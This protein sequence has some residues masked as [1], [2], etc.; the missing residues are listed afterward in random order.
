[1]TATAGSTTRSV[2]RAEGFSCPSCVAKIEKRVGRLPGV[3]DVTVKFASARVEVDHD[4]SV[5]STDEI[6]AAI[7]AAGYRATLSAF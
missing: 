3:R 4:P 5:T 1:M 7:G 6:I 2:F